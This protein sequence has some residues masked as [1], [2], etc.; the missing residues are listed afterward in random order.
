[1]YRTQLGDDEGMRFVFDRSGTYSFWMKNTL[2]PLDMLRVDEQMR[3]IEIVTAQ[4]CTAD[5]CPSYGGTQLAR[6][7]LEINAERA[8]QLWISTGHQLVIQ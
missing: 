5:P 1:M 4:P 8:E 3:V 6:Y 7:V 2:I